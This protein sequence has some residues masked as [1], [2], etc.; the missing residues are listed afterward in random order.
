MW[1]SQCC[2][3][4]WHQCSA[5][6]M[7]DLCDWKEPAEPVGTGVFPLWTPAK[8]AINVNATQSHNNSH[9]LC[10]INVVP[11]TVVMHELQDN[12]TC[13]CQSRDLDA[14]FFKPTWS[15]TLEDT[16]KFAKVKSYSWISTVCLHTSAA[17]SRQHINTFMPVRQTA[18]MNSLNDHETEVIKHITF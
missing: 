1:C 13:F 2:L 15:T 14:T 11:T 12:R 6:P 17:I 7:E 10:H 8:I 4:S 3:R 18:I 16:T 5:A 9:H